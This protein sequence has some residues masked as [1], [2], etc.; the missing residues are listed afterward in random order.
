ML[1]KMCPA[2]SQT[3]QVLSKTVSGEFSFDDLL[4]IVFVIYPSL[5]LALQD[6]MEIDQCRVSVLPFQL[7]ATKISPTSNTLSTELNLPSVKFRGDLSEE[8][9]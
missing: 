8:L 1:K 9:L 7:V 5:A 2:Q 6:A 4:I 3:P